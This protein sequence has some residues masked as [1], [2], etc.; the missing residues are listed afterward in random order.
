MTKNRT[1]LIL[2][3]ASLI[4]IVGLLFAFNGQKTSFKNGK[5]KSIV[6][7]NAFFNH[8]N[9]YKPNAAL[10]IT[11]TKEITDNER[12]FLNNKANGHACGYHYEIQ[13]WG[14][15]VCQIESTPFNQEC[16]E[17]L[18]NNSRIQSKMKGYIKQL[19]TKPTHYI[20][21]L[22]IAINNGPKDLL[23]SFENSGNHLFFMDGT[24]NH[25]TTLEFTY[26]QSA[27]IED[28]VDQSKWQGELD[29]NERNATNRIN[30]IIDSINTV[31]T[32]IEQSEISFPMQSFGGGII[33][34]QGAVSLKFK[35][36]TD[37][38]N[39][40]EIIERNNG[41]AGSEINP[42]H[43]Y[44]QLL[45]TSDNLE[46]IKKKLKDFKIVTEIYEYPRTK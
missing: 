13:F 14:S 7:K 31:V 28:L 24:S 44:V 20:Y 32:I 38:K 33:E 36:G 10:L 2:T 29:E 39:V 41:K 6:V 15:P 5:T 43:Y 18:R 8:T 17:F 19:E 23:K 46:T 9:I 26:L 11:D 30:E 27:P 12:H 25:H 40:K 45:H 1:K 35:N 3:L 42:Q 34:H 16:E 37:L 21:N 22:K 4:F